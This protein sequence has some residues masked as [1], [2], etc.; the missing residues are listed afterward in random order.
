MGVL[1]QDNELESSECCGLGDCRIKV[2]VCGGEPGRFR[3]GV[4]GSLM[5]TRFW[6]HRRMALGSVEART[7]QNQNRKINK[8]SK[9]HSNRYKI[10]SYLSLSLSLSLGKKMWSQAS[11]AVRK[12]LFF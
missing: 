10:K 4:K 9:V 5:N 6:S 2:R 8:Y 1:K 7:F 3:K 12:I 11:F